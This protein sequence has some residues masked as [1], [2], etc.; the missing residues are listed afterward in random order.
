VDAFYGRLQALR[1]LTLEVGE[2]EVVGI[3][4]PNGSGKTTT[5]RAIS[6]LVRTTGRIEL[7]GRSLAHL[8]A[9]AIARAGIAHVPEGRGTF[10]QLST[11]E[12]LAVAASA[13]VRGRR[14]VRRAVDDVL[15]HV[16][17]LAEHLDRPAELLSG[18]Q[19]QLLAIGRGL[20]L[21]PSLLMVDE[22][23]LGLAPKL[24]QELIAHLRRLQQEVGFSVLLVEQNAALAL[25][26][27]DRVYVLDNGA[28]VEA[29]EASSISVEGL[30]RRYLGTSVTSSVEL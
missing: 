14:A 27:T 16:P 2:G 9:D 26:V 23:T 24:A 28:A 17:Q 12:N 29:A 15:T 1:S 20:L 4:G 3:L 7:R 18:G 8:P 13:R 11:R 25:G 30:S 19:Q 22:P 5:L 21:N 10:P 6:G